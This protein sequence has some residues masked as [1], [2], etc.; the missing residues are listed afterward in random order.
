[1]P[2]Y[3]ADVKHMWGMTE[4]SPIGSLGGLK[5]S[6]LE[7][8][9][10]KDHIEF[11]VAQGRPHVLCDMRIVDDD[12]KEMP[13]DGVA[14]GHLQVWRGGDWERKKGEAHAWGIAV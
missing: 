12:G 8:V 3:G 2:S 11:K 7:E 14:V 9:D 5:A 6:V 1:M 13:H 4:L 10:P